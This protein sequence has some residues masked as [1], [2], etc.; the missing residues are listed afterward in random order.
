MSQLLYVDATLQDLPK[1][2]EIYN[3]TVASRM[4]TADTEP[5]SVE[6]KRNWFKAH[7][8]DKR[9]LWV[10]KDESN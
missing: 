9:P 8:P 3:S 7:S 2:V 1:I 5:V 6:S 4:V 10:I